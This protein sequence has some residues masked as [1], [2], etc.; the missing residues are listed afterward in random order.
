MH[1]GF[2]NK[3]FYG[4]EYIA[5]IRTSCVRETMNNDCNINHLED[6]LALGQII[7]VAPSVVMVLNSQLDLSLFL[8]SGISLNCCG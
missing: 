3:D 7:A 6:L 2:K 5:D 1:C 8:S 4:W